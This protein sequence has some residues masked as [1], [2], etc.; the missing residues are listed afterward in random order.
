MMPS[1]KRGNEQY[2]V[3]KIIAYMGEVPVEQIENRPI[4]FLNEKYPLMIKRVMNRYGKE[5][6]S[7][8]MKVTTDLLTSCCS[9]NI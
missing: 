2:G 9:T 4:H 1:V 8:H 3:S 6:M 5:K 7:I